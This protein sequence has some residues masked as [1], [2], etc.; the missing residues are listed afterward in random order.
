MVAAPLLQCIGIVIVIG[1]ATSEQNGDNWGWKVVK[2]MLLEGAPN[3][4]SRRSKLECRLES[5]D[6]C[7]V[8]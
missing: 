4:Y 8:N 7:V 2:E 3:D 6:N 1:I 5:I